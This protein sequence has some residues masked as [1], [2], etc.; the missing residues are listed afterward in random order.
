MFTGS[1]SSGFD[2]Q[3]NIA[4]KH[5]NIHAFIDFIFNSNSD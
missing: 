2:V 5:N 3:P 1:T 4:I